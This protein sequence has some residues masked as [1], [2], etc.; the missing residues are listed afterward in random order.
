MDELQR[1][2]QSL[3]EALAANQSLAES[4][5]RMTAERDRVILERDGHR[6]ELVAVQTA[7]AQ[8]SRLAE[9]LRQQGREQLAAKEK[10]HAEAVKRLH[11]QHAADAE[12]QKA[13]EG[14]L[15]RRAQAAEAALA[16]AIG[17]RD[18]A[19]ALLAKHDPEMKADAEQKARAEKEAERDKLRKQLD[20]LERDLA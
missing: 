1:T 18:E 2:K 14:D 11:E 9:Q 3:A 10:E 4:L 5:G 12:K 15:S 7:R 19:R 16:A 17:E 13:R 6:G 8:Q 20:A